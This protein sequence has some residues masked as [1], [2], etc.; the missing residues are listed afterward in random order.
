[1][2]AGYG[3]KIAKKPVFQAGAGYKKQESTSFV[4]ISAFANILTN[5]DAL[6]NRLIS[7]LR[8]SGDL[9]T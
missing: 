8:I 7:C 3:P 9:Y 5:P 4:N 1:M 2:E 6:K